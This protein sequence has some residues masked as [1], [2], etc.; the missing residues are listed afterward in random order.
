VRPAA[1]S[2]VLKLVRGSLRQFVIVAGCFDCCVTY[3]LPFLVQGEI[4]EMQR[5]GPANREGGVRVNAFV[6]GG[7]LKK[8]APSSRV[9]VKLE[10][11]IHICD[12]Y[13]T[14]AALAGVDH[15]DH[16]AALAKLV[17][18]ALCAVRC[19][20]AGVL[21][22][23]RRHDDGAGWVCSQ[24]PVDGLNMAPWLLG[25]AEKSPVSRV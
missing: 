11:F 23:A 20:L 19:S 13:T 24:P 5:P 2:Q 25:L 8:V 4:E 3:V 12:Y 1:W 7:F 22:S 14:L 6:S 17:R 15:V 21:P 16:R 10:G 9:G 18:W